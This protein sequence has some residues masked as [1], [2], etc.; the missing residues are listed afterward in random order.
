MTWLN[1]LTALAVVV[2]FGYLIMV[3]MKKNN[4]NAHSGLKEFFSGGLYKEEDKTVFPQDIIEQV[5][6]ERRTMM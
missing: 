3:Q 4:P 6:D 2:A 1:G 5:Y